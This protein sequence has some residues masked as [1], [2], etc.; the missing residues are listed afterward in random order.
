MGLESLRRMPRLETPEAKSLQEASTAPDGE[1]EAEEEEPDG[2]WL[3]VLMYGMEHLV[4]GS[5]TGTLVAFGALAF[6]SI[7]GKEDNNQSIGGVI[8][9]FS[10]AMCAVVHFAIGNAEVA[11]AKSIFRRTEGNR[12]TIVVRAASYW[13]AWLSTILQFVSMVIGMV[14]LL[15]DKPPA[16]LLKYIVPYFQIKV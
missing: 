15:W 2:A 1:P 10:I 9:L 6:Q 12:R 3:D 11:R 4:R 14:L 5:D 13:I 8:L 16:V 7:Q